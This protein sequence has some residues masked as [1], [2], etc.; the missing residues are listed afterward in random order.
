MIDSWTALFRDLEHRFR[1][2]VRSVTFFE[3]LF[4]AVVL[5]GGLGIWYEMVFKGCIKDEWCMKSITAALF[6]YFPAI[7][8]T[9]LIDWT[10][11][12]QPYRRSFGL[13]AAGGFALIF[14][15]AV[16]T[17]PLFQLFWAVIG[18][19]LA[20]LFWWLANG[21]KNCFRDINPEAA[22]PP[23][24]GDLPGGTNGWTT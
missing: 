4:L 17:S 9:A 20:V 13:I 12:N 1:A 23:P 14:I 19:I 18:T 6:T 24:T 11:E 10:H 2:P 8:A 16:T 15:L 5:G 7:V 22:T 3:H 21:E